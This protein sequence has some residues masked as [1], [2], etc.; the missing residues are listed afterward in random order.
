MLRSKDFTYFTKETLYIVTGD[1]ISPP[2]TSPTN[3]SIYPESTLFE[4]FQVI[5]VLKKFY[6][7]QASTNPSYA[8]VLFNKL[9]RFKVLLP[10]EEEESIFNSISQ[11]ENQNS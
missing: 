7:V 3:L 2:I 1:H 10:Y 4:A 11:V 5:K 9:C 8:Q 6:S